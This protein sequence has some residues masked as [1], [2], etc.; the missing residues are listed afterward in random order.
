MPRQ[1][2]PLERLSNL[3][4]VLLN[5]KRP[6][7][8]REISQLVKGYPCYDE[9]IAA[10]RKSFE[11]DRK[12]LAKEGLEVVAV[13]VS[14]PDQYGYELH[15]DR[16]ILED[17]RLTSSEKLA[18]YLATKLIQDTDS[19]PQL[20]EDQQDSLEFSDFLNDVNLNLWVP[21]IVDELSLAVKRRAPLLVKYKDYELIVR[22]LRL[23]FSRSGWYLEVLNKQEELRSLRVDQI[24]EIKDV[25]LVDTESL[26]SQKN[27]SEV[28]SGDQLVTIW[29]DELYS[30][31]LERESYKFEEF[32]KLDDG[33]AVIK[34]YID[35]F[36]R[37]RTWLLSLTTHAVVLAPE[38]VRQK[39]LKWI[40]EIKCQ[41]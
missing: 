12:Q 4:V 10:V 22:P 19:S 16:P 1:I 27:V 32:R 17:L 2:D 34:L 30:N 40:N 13:K 15:S 20:L 7:T 37:F 28:F 8:L 26:D 11:R 36:D 39:I 5:S 29:V 38:E 14:G 41:I 33:S 21:K 3:I 24:R 35:Y 18:Y 23:R 31:F 25:N 6:L 9:N